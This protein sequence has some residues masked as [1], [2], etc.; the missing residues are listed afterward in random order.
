MLCQ[1]NRRSPGDAACRER[2]KQ[3]LR[4]F[5]GDAGTQAPVEV[6]KVRIIKGFDVKR[7][8]PE[9]EVAAG[10]GRP[11]SAAIGW[12]VQGEGGEDFVERGQLGTDI[13][14]A[15]WRA[16]WKSR[17]EEMRRMVRFDDESGWPCRPK[18]RADTEDD[19]F[20]SN[21]PPALQNP[22]AGGVCS[23]RLGDGRQNCPEGMGL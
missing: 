17:M 18:A 21:L 8:V 10:S 9:P 4:N 12:R 3:A 22:A 19:V 6:W 23:A 14:P 20:C 11:R 2:M 15:A 16:D 13:F 7:A 5:K 1:V